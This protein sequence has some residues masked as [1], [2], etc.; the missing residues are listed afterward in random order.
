[1]G[2]RVFFHKKPTLE[3][4]RDLLPGIPEEECRDQLERLPERYFLLFDR[5]TLSRYG[6]MLASLGERR[7][8]FFELHEGGGPEVEVRVIAF[9]REALFSL[10]AGA[11][12][13][14][15]MN[16]ET[17][18]IF[19]YSAEKGGEEKAGTVPF[20]FRGRRGG[21]QRGNFDLSGDRFGGRPKKVVDVFRG[22]LWTGE[23][24]P[25]TG[26]ETSRIL[27]EI[28]ETFY[29]NEEDRPE[30]SAERARERLSEELSRKL[31]FRRERD[32]A[33]KMYPLEM[34]VDSLPGG[35][36]RLHVRSQD[37]PFF[38][39][40]FG[41]VLALHRISIEHVEIKTDRRGIEDTF[42]VKNSLG[43]PI[44]DEKQLSSLRLSILFTKQFTH[45]LWNAPDPYRALTRFETLVRDFPLIPEEG[46][47]DSLV[48]DSRVLR[49]LSRLLGASD[50]LWE[51]FIRLQYENIIPLLSKDR[52]TAGIDTSREGLERELHGLLD[53]AGSFEEKKR[54]LNEF[55]DRC[56]YLVDLEHILDPGGDF[57]FLS[58]GLSEIAELVV[59]KA[60]EFAWE[61][62]TEVHG[63]P[64]T[65]AGL[66]TE[67]AVTGLGK[68]GGKALGYASDIELLVL[69]RDMGETSGPKKIANTEFFIRLVRTASLIIESKREG[70]Y[71]VDLRLRPHG[72]G[73]PLAVSLAQFV[74]YFRDEASSLEKLSLV[75]L[76]AV[77]GSAE[78]GAQVE[79]LRDSLIYEG[80][81]IDVEE[82]IRL[83]RIQAEKYEAAGRPNA[84]YG[85]GG[86]VDLEYTL[87]VLQVFEGGKAPELR[88]PYLH[89]VFHHFAGRGILD[90][91]TVDL[92]RESYFF[93]R[94]LINA[95]RM[96]R[97]NAL[98]LYLPERDALEFSHVAR[99][100][101]Y[102][103]EEASGGVSAEEQLWIDY[104]KHTAVVRNFVERRL[105][106]HAVARK[107]TGNI[108]D[109]LLAEAMEDPG[110]S[111]FSSRFQDSRRLFSEAG[112]LHPRR[113]F[114]NFLSIQG[115]W[116]SSSR[117][118]ETALL[119]WDYL[120]GSPDPDMAL[121]NWERFV[122]A[123]QKEGGQF[124]EFYHQPK[125]LEILL[126]I[127]GAG[128]YLADQLTK[129]PGFF[130]LVTDPKKIEVPMTYRD[131]YGELTGIRMGMVG[132]SADAAKNPGR[133]VLSRPNTSIPGTAEWRRELRTFRHRHILR[134]SS[135]DIC[136]GAPLEA[137][138]GELS[139]LAE[140]IV[141][142][143]LEYRL[144]DAGN[145][146][147][148]A[149]CI[150]AFG[151][152][153]GNE[154]NYSSDI[155]LVVLY[156][157]G[158]DR[159][160][161]GEKKQ[162]H[163]LIRRLRSDIADITE[164][165][166]VYRVD[167]RLRPYGRSGELVFTPRQMEEYYDRAAALWE[168][169]ALLKARP[170][171]GNRSLGTTLLKKLYVIMFSRLDRDEVLSSVLKARRG[172]GNES[173]RGI[174]VKEDPGGI[175]DIEFLVQAL[176]LLHSG[177]QGDLISGNTLE[178]L[179][180]LAEHG[181]IAKET[182]AE[183]QEAYR[184][185]RRVEH[186]LQLPEDRQEQYLPRDR[187]AFDTLG[188]RMRWTQG[189]GGNFSEY[190]DS[191]M[192]KV[193]RIFLSLLGSV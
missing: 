105:G 39:Y 91:G 180:L 103:S 88:S 29:K 19:T 31:L 57:M 157:R 95:L 168:F 48:A 75:R 6:G 167:F 101:G 164:H 38:L 145:I 171:A 138:T 70:I 59:R 151:K 144:E 177:T 146:E 130:T 98:D 117:F 100:M 189:Y 13:A 119:A 42:F 104:R 125:R 21:T 4:Y 61:R 51:D 16:I 192:K 37:T 135:R 126:R 183:L 122:A 99:R 43:D 139:G 1:V 102:R 148:D 72:S 74:S 12:S 62:M 52:V 169:Q 32:R 107:G 97:G 68:F 191:T 163:R 8:Y 22:R 140:A 81:S 26:P 84:K 114:A 11:L 86:L 67:Y 79:R 147:A 34:E 78:F 172:R 50:F 109:L 190:L 36:T 165:G 49:R 76:R 2:K 128:R 89:E 65:V 80:G 187:H 87:L 115:L 7:P 73:G 10:V 176:Q 64:L 153:G 15:G 193:D 33:P 175:R 110:R 179:A 155:D 182:A 25:E 181:L 185:L 5:P 41:T 188:R 166:M 170:I 112:F 143:A 108:A 54:V 156:D 131:F 113:A 142:A 20:D 96:L 133:V 40:A 159:L 28:L 149:L 132:A 150:L 94:R 55:K 77:A 23:G 83:R 85:P 137:I 46:A 178:A 90:A 30:K 152:L 106:S 17:G 24:A 160:E 111:G 129:N 69:Y 120:R 53:K 93:L 27:G 60:F 58:E 161:E 154:L 92:L 47:A 82:L 123:L 116:P 35:S 158:E 134:I 66:P 14:G 56:T 124:E 136:Y 162:L 18:D 44:T 174:N 173:G 3:A 118:L 184:F 121:N 71:R 141:Q 45:F 186:F 9:D 127:C 63:R